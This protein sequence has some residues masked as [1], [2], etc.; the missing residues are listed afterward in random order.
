M[1][2][3][4]AEKTLSPQFLGA[5]QWAEFSQPTASKSATAQ[6]KSE[7]KAYTKTYQGYIKG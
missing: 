3:A 5:G 2:C 4:A 6:P 7:S 1:V